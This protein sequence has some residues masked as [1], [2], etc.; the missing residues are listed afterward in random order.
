[1]ILDLAKRLAPSDLISLG[2]VSAIHLHNAPFGVN[3]PVAQDFLV[4]A[5]NP[6][7]PALPFSIVQAADETIALE[8]IETFILSDDDDVFLSSGAGAQEIFG[9]AFFCVVIKT[10]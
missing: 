3:G 2:A 5:G 8:N 4:D 7:G 9:G 10:Y 6:S 1:M